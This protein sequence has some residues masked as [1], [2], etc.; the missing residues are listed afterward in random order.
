MDQTR[1]NCPP[2]A[3]TVR[4]W[5]GR[6][7]CNLWTDDTG[8]RHKCWSTKGMTQGCSVSSGGYGIG[9]NSTN[10]ELDEDIASLWK[11][12]LAI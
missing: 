3:E 2:I 8:T 1:R 12:W 10:D 11:Q 9:T 5:Y 7:T 6:P 4:Q